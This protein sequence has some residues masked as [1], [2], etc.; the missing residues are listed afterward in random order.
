MTASPRDRRL[1]LLATVG[2]AYA[3]TFRNLGDYLQIAWAWLIVMTSLAALTSWFFWPSHVAAQEAGATTSWVQMLTTFLTMMAGASIAVAWHSLLLNGERPATARYLRLD[4]VVWRYLLVGIAMWAPVFV[5]TYLVP[6]DGYDRDD[7][8]RLAFMAM[9]VVAMIVL[10]IVLGIKLLP[11]LPAIAI[12]KGHVSLGA[13]WRA[14][15]RSWW[16][17]FACYLLTLL[18]PLFVASLPSFIA[19]WRADEDTPPETQLGFVLSNTQSELTMLVS[20]IFAV[21]F[22]SLAF[23]HFFPDAIA[24]GVA[25]DGSGDAS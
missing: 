4:G 10:G 15:H 14:T 1:P 9:L 5:G 18:P 13:V 6:G 11:L 23:R 16:R 21:S 19:L 17:L 24:E 25:S 22:L 2:E 8:P 12:R 3:L 20:S 7:L